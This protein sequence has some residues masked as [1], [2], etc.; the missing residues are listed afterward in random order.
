[1]L[2]LSLVTY[3]KLLQNEQVTLANVLSGAALIRAT[4]VTVVALGLSSPLV[5]ERTVVLEVFW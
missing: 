3:A 4:W 5:A 2:G 1:M